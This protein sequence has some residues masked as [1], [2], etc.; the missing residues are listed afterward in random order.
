MR[1][2]RNLAAAV[3]AII[4]AVLLPAA[5][6]I[7][8]GEA[9]EPGELRVDTTLGS[10]GVVWF[11]SGDT[12][13]D[14]SMTVEFRANGSGSWGQGAPAV[15]AVPGT[16]VDGAAL[17]IDSWG[18]SAMFLEP[19]TDYEVR[20]TLAD[21]DGGGSVQTVEATT[22][23]VPQPGG[24]IRHV[25]PGTGGGSGTQ[26]DPF[27]GLQAAANAATPGDTFEMAAGVYAPFEILASGAA[28][29]PITFRGPGDGIVVLD[30]NGTDRGVVTIGQFDRP[31]SHII[32]EGLT[33]T[34]G[35]WGID[36]QNTQDIV[37][38]RNDLRRVD[39]GIINRRDRDLERRQIVCDNVVEGRTPWPGTG[40]PDEQGIDLRGWGNTVCHNEVW[41]FGDCISIEPQHGPSFGNDAYG[42]DVGRCVDDGIEIDYNQANVRV[43]ANRVTNSRTGVSVQPI[44]GGPAY[45]VRNEFFNLESRPI[46]LNNDPAGLYIAHNTGVMNGNAMTSNTR[47][48]NTTF[49]NNLFLGIRYAFEFLTPAVTGY[50]DLD[51][52][53]WGTSR[54]VDPGSAWFKWDDVRYDRIGDLPAGVEDNGVEVGFS[55]LVAAPLP[56]DWDVEVDPDASDPRLRSGSAAVDAGAVLPNLNDATTINGAPD[57]GAFELGAAR[58]VYGTRS[59]VGSRF[60]DVDPD[61]IFKADIEWLADQGV[62]RG[63][64]PPANDRFCPDESVTRGQMAA[65]LVRALGYSAAG[66]VDFVDDNSSVFE[67]DIEKLA[68]AGVTRAVTRPPTI[69]SVPT[70]R[71]PAARWPHSCGER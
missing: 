10:L 7:A 42:N 24:R 48:T 67:S 62:T 56:A 64:N 43:W 41:S 27:R 50:R 35:E 63:C 58:P 30:G 40:I 65:F 21:P 59:Q 47:W 4:G 3:A 60:S 9:I 15:R 39:N 8:A 20:V 29:S 69:G 33:I 16:V 22:L 19:G 49:R 51:H 32:I 1:G 12:D 45:I 13:L 54:T 18:A 17:T 31:T 2:S 23:T 66:S 61:N 14:S 6:A 57:A 46:K 5:P 25:V 38:T 71:S 53:A 70:I 28:G 36:A 55:D 34:D 11:V 52:N 44:Y 26:G 68:T 37:I